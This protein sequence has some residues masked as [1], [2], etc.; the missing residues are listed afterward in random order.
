MNAVLNSPK[1]GVFIVSTLVVLM[2]GALMSY[3]MVEGL[4]DNAPLNQITGAMIVSFTG[5]VNYWIGSS[6]SSKDKDLV[7]AKQADTSA[8]VAATTAAKPNA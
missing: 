2:F 7:I 5:I 3:A 1:L 6:S 4:Q 8:V